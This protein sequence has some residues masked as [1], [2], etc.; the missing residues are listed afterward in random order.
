[1]ETLQILYEFTRKYL[2]K[3]S[4][5]HLTEKPVC[6]KLYF[7]NFSVF[8]LSLNFK[9][10]LFEKNQCLYFREKDFLETENRTSSIAFAH[11]ARLRTTI[12]SPGYQL[13]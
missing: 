9:S 12:S 11:A 13:K 1:M 8:L 6:T 4:L 5:S 2:V 3:T 10:T 7:A